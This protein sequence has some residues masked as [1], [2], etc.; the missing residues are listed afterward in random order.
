MLDIPLP[1]DLPLALARSDAALPARRS[2]ESGV[3]SHHRITKES[4][5]AQPN[6]ILCAPS[7]LAMAAR[8]L[9]GRAEDVVALGKRLKATPRWGTNNTTLEAVAAALF[10]EFQVH[11]EVTATGPK[12]EPFAPAA[13]WRAVALRD[14][15]CHLERG[16]FVVANYRE[17]KDGDGH[18]AI[19]ERLSDAEVVLTDP[20]HGLDLTLPLDRFDW[21]S[22]HNNPC[23]LGWRLVI[24]RSERLVLGSLMGAS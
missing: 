8:V 4:Y 5:L 23:L 22:E 16:A 21:R 9:T 10:P 24:H 3:S 14:L 12:G 2:A 6:N 15:A 7:V 18:Y 20:K 19:I 13:P 11:S 17:P 1:H